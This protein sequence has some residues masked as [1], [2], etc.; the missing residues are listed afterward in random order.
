MKEIQG[1]NLASFAAYLFAYV[2]AIFWEK[3]LLPENLWA[4]K[5]IKFSKLKKLKN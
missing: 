5:Q 2:A 3:L 1:S 4:A